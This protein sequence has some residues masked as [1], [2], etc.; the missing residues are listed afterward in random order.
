MSLQRRS[1]SNSS[2]NSVSVVSA[3]GDHVRPTENSMAAIANSLALM[4]F[5]HF[6]HLGGR[7]HDAVLYL[8]GLGF[9]AVLIWAITRPARSASS[10]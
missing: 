6:G 1:N 7:G 10:R 2:T 5:G 4:R 3:V 8:A 9:A